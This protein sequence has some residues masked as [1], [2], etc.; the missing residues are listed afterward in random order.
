MT[1]LFDREKL[2]QEKFLGLQNKWIIQAK[3]KKAERMEALLN[4]F[5][6]A[7]VFKQGKTN[8]LVLYLPTTWLG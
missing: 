6:N 7:P 2:I 5:N 3:P 1:F 4:N 8:L